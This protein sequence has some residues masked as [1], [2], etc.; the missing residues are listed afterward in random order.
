MHDIMDIFFLKEK[1]VKIMNLSCNVMYFKQQQ[2][3]AFHNFLE[4]EMSKQ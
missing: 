2:Q 1:D 4:L 3:T